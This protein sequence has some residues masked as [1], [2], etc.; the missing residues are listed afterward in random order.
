MGGT[1]QLQTTVNSG[2]GAIEARNGAQVQLLNGAVINNANFSAS[3]ASS[4]ITTVAGST[5]TLGGGTISGPMTIHD[6]SHL[7]LAADVSY[8]GTLSL[9]SVGN[10]TS[11]QVDGARSLTGTATVQM[12]NTTANQI[13]GKNV[14]GDAFTLSS[15]ITVQ[16]S[17]VIG[18]NNLALVNNG[19]LIATQS[20]GLTLSSGGAVTNNNVIRGDGSVFSIAGTHLNQGA[21][22]VVDAVNGG[23]VR[24]IGN[25]TVSGGTFTTASGG[26]IAT[27]SGNTAGVSGVRN[28]GTLDIVDNSA[29]LLDGT[30]TNDGVI[31]M[32]SLGNPTDL[33]TTGNRLIDGTGTINLSNVG[34]NRIIAATAGDRLTLGSGQTLQGAGQIGAGGQLEFTNHGTLI[35]NQSNALTISSS[36][37][38]INNNI[39]RADGG[40]V[41]ISGT[42]VGQGALGVLDAVNNGIVRLVGNSTVSGGTFTTASGGADRHAL[43][44]HRRCERRQEYRYAE[45]RRQLGPAA[46]WHLNQRRCDQYAIAG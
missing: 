27:L 15:G 19:S 40:T 23:I 8:N 35:G 4:L 21:L 43:R 39:V 34:T 13:R 45:H 32:Q 30:L 44:Q 10:P 28:T 42:Q 2:G 31:N 9:A 41:I 16:G 26:R 22:G 29:L 3:G 36:G 14:N 7:V 18:G 6:N 25:S 17:G 24:L 12:S 5:V 20:Q 38:V 1:L 33:R 11:L 46:R 37:T